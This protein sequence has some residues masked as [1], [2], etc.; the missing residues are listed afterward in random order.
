[1]RRLFG[2]LAALLGAVSIALAARYGYKGA[3]TLADGVISGVVFGLI[4]L[5]AFLFDAAAVRLWF[6]RFRLGAGLIGAIAALALVVTFTNSLGAIAGRADTTLADR[7]RA[8]DEVTADRAELARLTKERGALA[9]F[10]PATDEDV[11]AA[12]EAVAAAE[13]VRVAECDKRGTRCRERETEEQVKRESLSTVLANKGLTARAAKLDADAELVRARLARAPL[14]QDANPLGSVLE[15]LI[16]AG[17]AALTAWQQAVVAGV[18]ELCLVGVMVI[19]ELLGHSQTIAIF[20]A[21]SIATIPAPPTTARLPQA[22]PAPRQSP[23]GKAAPKSRNLVS[24]AIAKR[25]A[26]HPAGEVQSEQDVCA[27]LAPL[28]RPTARPPPTNNDDRGSV[29]AFMLEHVEP[30][31]GED[32]D[33]KML[34]TEYRSWCLRKSYKPMD[35]SGFTD[36]LE[37]ICAKTRID[38][39]TKGNRVFCRNVRLVPAER[40]AEKTEAPA[41]GYQSQ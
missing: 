41:A 32:L 39:E 5:C 24:L 37:R 8:K 22:H 15:R 10:T 21:A 40:S 31:D 17:A 16:G 7:A 1:M 4:A 2:C 18:F 35:L 34:L 27:T 20:G 13:R 6:M 11:A 25:G 29:R 26:G 38:I 33:V 14:V 3:D 30:A 12:R 19:F 9:A 23:Q 28:V 36:E